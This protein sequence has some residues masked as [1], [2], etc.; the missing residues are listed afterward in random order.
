MLV[1]KTIIDSEHN[2]NN[3]KVKV[4]TVIVNTIMSK[5]Y[6]NVMTVNTLI[7]NTVLIVNMIIIIH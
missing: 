4:N 1:N 7:V 2:N 5:H 3:Y 6:D